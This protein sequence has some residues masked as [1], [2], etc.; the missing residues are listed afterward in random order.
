MRGGVPHPRLGRLGRDH[1]VAKLDADHKH[2]RGALGLSE[3]AASRQTTPVCR[4]R[5]VEHS[6][7]SP[8]D[9]P[10]RCLSVGGAAGVDA[11]HRGT[12]GLSEA[13]ASRQ[14]TPVWEG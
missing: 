3:A 4:M 11:D 7:E 8:H 6:Q 1:Q 10:E 5:S 13:T 12:L 2:H 9:P 14:T